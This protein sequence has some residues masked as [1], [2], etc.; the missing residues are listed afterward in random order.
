MSK[1]KTTSKNNIN[2]GLKENFIK[3]SGGVGGG[4]FFFER[5]SFG[6]FISIAT[7]APAVDFCFANARQRRRRV[8]RR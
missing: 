2:C 6:R 1:K 3:N 5:K 4:V 8:E 7:A